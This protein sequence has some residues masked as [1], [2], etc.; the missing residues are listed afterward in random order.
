MDSR[1]DTERTNK[2]MD[3][4]SD[5]SQEEWSSI[6]S[7]IP[8]H[9]IHFEGSIPDKEIGNDESVGSR[10]EAKEPAQDISVGSR[11]NMMQDEM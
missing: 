4:Q 2:Q 9:R 8:S 11:L 5:A 10:E 3:T 6:Q 1:K 7:S